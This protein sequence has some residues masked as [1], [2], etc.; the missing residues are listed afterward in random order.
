M[1]HLIVYMIEDSVGIGSARLL[2]VE[3]VIISSDHTIVY[4]EAGL[5]VTARSRL[6]II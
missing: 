5:V 2:P 1:M 4:L 6:F 3:H